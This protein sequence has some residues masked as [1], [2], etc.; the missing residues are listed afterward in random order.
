MLRLAQ[1]SKKQSGPR[2]LSKAWRTPNFGEILVRPPPFK[3]FASATASLLQR[4]SKSQQV[5][6]SIAFTSD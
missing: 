4:C 3:M 5:A 1:N 2:A 6:L